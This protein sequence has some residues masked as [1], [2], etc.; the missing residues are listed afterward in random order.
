M[1]LSFIRLS[2]IG[3]FVHLANSMAVLVTAATADKVLE[4]PLTYSRTSGRPGQFEFLDPYVIWRVPLWIPVFIFSMLA[5]IDH[6]L[7]IVLSAQ[8]SGPL[9]PLAVSRL[10]W[11]EYTYSASIMMVV[12]LMLC[13][14]SDI[15]VLVL[16]ARLYA[17]AMDTA[18]MSDEL[19][20]SFVTEAVGVW[21]SRDVSEG[22]LSDRNVLSHVS[23]QLSQNGLFNTLFPWFSVWFALIAADPPGF[24]Y[25]I[26]F[27]LFLLFA[28][29]GVVQMRY[30]SGRT[31]TILDRNKHLVVLS[32][33]AKTALV[34]QI[35]ANALVM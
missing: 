32:L 3:L 25:G 18:F 28:L 15:F 4:L 21:S 29:F 2:W 19:Y 9:P 6:L 27:S 12:I 14:I 13:G 8:R 20:E 7:V 33:T 24:V 23:N 10:V 5:A 31:K 16:A 34:W 35:Y 26:V 22:V 17:A 11:F 30:L 1:R